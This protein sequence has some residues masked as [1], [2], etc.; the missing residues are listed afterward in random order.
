MA[1]VTVT[2]KGQITIPA[3]VRKSLGIEKGDRFPIVGSGFAS[4]GYS[5]EIGGDFMRTILVAMTMTAFSYAGT[6]L[7]PWISDNDQYLS[8]IVIENTSDVAVTVT[9]TAHGTVSQ[10][11]AT[12]DILPL[13]RLELSPSMLF[14]E[15]GS[16]SFSVVM[17][18]PSGCLTA[19]WSTKKRSSNPIATHGF[20]IP[21]DVGSPIWGDSLLF[22]FG[23]S[24][25]R[26]AV[27]IN[28]S[29]RSVRPGAFFVDQ[30]GD[31][32]FKA[33]LGEV[34]PFKPL[35][36]TSE[37]LANAWPDPAYLIVHQPSTA[38]TG[39]AFAFDEERNPTALPGTAIS[40]DPSK[41]AGGTFSAVVKADT[42]ELPDELLDAYLQDAHRL[43]STWISEGHH[44][45]EPEIPG[46]LVKT[47][48]NLLTH[49][50]TSNHPVRVLVVD[51]YRI[52]PF[53]PVLQSLVVTA[54]AS[55]GWTSSWLNGQTITGV[56][57][58][59]EFLVRYELQNHGVI[60]TREDGRFVLVFRTPRMLHM[61]NV[62]EFFEGFNG[63]VNAT[64]DG[65]VGD[66]NRIHV[67][68]EE[69]YRWRLTYSHG[70]GDC[71]SGCVNR[72]FWE[73]TVDS[74]GEVEFVNE[75]GDEL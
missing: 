41:F 18:D 26:A 46:Y 9:L 7:F 11:T 73:F 13:E 70:W 21:V 67:V 33:Q 12:V 6:A 42:H 25:Y 32:I 37:L 40:F 72:H 17:N 35:V 66:G 1:T 74:A 58:I 10:D 49:M 4:I 68:L 2:S 24:E 3:T 53:G 30:F 59:D 15:I 54:D 57:E 69:D 61:P 51:T 29:T 16:P 52:R 14:T 44:W 36:A 60:A 23:Q 63:V 34:E 50:A 65:L 38:L 27:V 31:L 47:F 71:L 5:R 39:I 55:F 64:G 48:Y 75:W 43:A 8:T 20:A 62:A 56:E 19:T 45:A 28:A 22:A